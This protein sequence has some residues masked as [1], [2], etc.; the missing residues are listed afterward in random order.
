MISLLSCSSS[1]DENVAK[2]FLSSKI[3]NDFI[4]PIQFG[5]KL[6]NFEISNFKI[7][8]YNPMKVISENEYELTGFMSMN[9]VNPQ[10]NRIVNAKE[11]IEV[12]Y[13]FT[14]STD[15]NWYLTDIKTKNRALNNDVL[16]Y[17]F[18]KWKENFI[19]SY[20]NEKVNK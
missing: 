4:L 15:D 8:R 20:S 1:I 19:S 3:E 14:K 7:I 5:G 6:R 10:F 11:L 9:A 16:R 17:S 13:T 18:A 12:A 2:S